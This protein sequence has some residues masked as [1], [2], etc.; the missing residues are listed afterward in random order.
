[1]L[2]CE[3]SNVITAQLHAP[4][5]P[6]FSSLL[7]AS[8]PAGGGASAQQQQLSSS[9]LHLCCKQVQQAGPCRVPLGRMTRRGCM[10]R[11]A[12]Q[13]LAGISLLLSLPT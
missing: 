3:A 12:R 13:P 9:T 8:S 6:Q 4:P 7:I 5:V 2:L 10:A 1:M 11:L